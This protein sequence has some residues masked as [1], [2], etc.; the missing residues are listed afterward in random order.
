MIADA[1]TAGGRLIATIRLT[2]DQGGPLCATVPES[3][4]GWDRLRAADRHGKVF[5]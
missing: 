4:V 2:D 3:H 1:L 5:R